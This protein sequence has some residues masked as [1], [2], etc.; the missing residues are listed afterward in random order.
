MYIFRYCTAKSNNVIF[1]KRKFKDL[2][3][4]FISCLVKKN[5]LKMACTNLTSDY[6]Y[7]RT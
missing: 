2:S 4:R 3:L 6:F 5:V 1:F 7:Y